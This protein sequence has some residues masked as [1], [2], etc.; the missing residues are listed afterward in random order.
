[1]RFTVAC[2]AVF[3]GLGCTAAARADSFVYSALP[4]VEARPAFAEPLA[5]GWGTTGYGG[6][7]WYGSTSQAKAPALVL[8]AEEPQETLTA[9]TPSAAAPEPSSIALLGTGGLGLVALLAGRRRSAG[10]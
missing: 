4:H 2:L 3:C 9:G 1:M 7:F 5:G 10:L 6:A 8:P